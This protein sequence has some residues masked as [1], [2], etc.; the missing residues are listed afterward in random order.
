MANVDKGRLIRWLEVYRPTVVSSRWLACFF[1]G[2]MLPV[3]QIQGKSS[4][5]P[6]ESSLV[7]VC[8]VNTTWRDCLYVFSKDH[9]SIG[10]NIYSFSRCF[11]IK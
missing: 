9:Y 10:V 2:H 4:P 1:C 11:Y 5:I 8:V 3:Q 7:C 6:G